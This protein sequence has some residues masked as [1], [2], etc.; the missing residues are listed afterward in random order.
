MFRKDLAGLLQHGPR[1]V[2]EPLDQPHRD[3]EADLRHLPRSLHGGPSQVT[4]A[5]ARGRKGGFVFGA[6]K[7]GKCPGRKTARISEPRIAITR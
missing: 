2:A 6:G 3:M 1:S 5:P 7:P 4:R